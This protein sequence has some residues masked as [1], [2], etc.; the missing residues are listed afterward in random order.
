MT[1]FTKAFGTAPGTWA[2]YSYDSVMVLVNSAKAAGSFDTAALTAA[3][4]APQAVSGW[5]GSIAFDPATGNRTPAPV[6]VVSTSADGTL[7][8]DQSWVSSTGFTF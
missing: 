7:H 6:V 4:Q 8:I 1:N 5:T 2:P 3:L